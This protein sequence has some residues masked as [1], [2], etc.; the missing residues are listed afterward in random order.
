MKLVNDP[1]GGSTNG[2]HLADLSYATSDIVGGL[3]RARRIEVLPFC[4]IQFLQEVRT[5]DLIV[6]GVVAGDFVCEGSV[7]LH[8]G[9]MLRGS[10]AAHSVVVRPGADMLG[11]TRILHGKLESFG[12]TTSTWQWRCQSPK[13]K[14]DCESV[15]FLQH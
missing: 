9:A 2:S 4:E 5:G 1:S 13:P 10:V 14:A 15:V 3:V 6:H 7:V 11:E 12:R 8:P